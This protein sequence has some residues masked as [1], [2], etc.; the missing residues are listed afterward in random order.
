MTTACYRHPERVAPFYCQKD[1][2]Y[3]C[4]DCACCHNPRIYC[5]F[6]TAC[7]IDLLI[8]EGEL[9]EC[10]KPRGETGDS[11]KVSETFQ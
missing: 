7:V 10:G 9:S 8:K 3:M 1:S 11:S 6:R 4:R 2:H 5:Q